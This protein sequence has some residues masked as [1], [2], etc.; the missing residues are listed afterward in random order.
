MKIGE[1]D[2]F[3]GG[4]ETYRIRPGR[5]FGPASLLYNG[6]WI[7]TGGIAAGAWR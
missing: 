5:P 6:Y 3:P 1:T 4:G 7:I 2:P